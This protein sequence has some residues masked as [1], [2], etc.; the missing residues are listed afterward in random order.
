MPFDSN[1]GKAAKE[2]QLKDKDKDQDDVDDRM[3]Y[4]R[5]M[6]KL[7]SCD[8]NTLRKTFKITKHKH[9][10]YPKPCKENLNPLNNK[11]SKRLKNTRGRAMVQAAL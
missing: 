10:N 5:H 3:K 4:A 8:Y 11:T 9:R 7:Y 1:S 2:K 6:K